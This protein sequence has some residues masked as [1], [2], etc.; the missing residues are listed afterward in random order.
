MNNI[1]LTIFTPAFN[2]ANTLERAY[3]SLKNQT[4]KNFEWL[5]IDDGSTDDTENVI[6]NLIDKKEVTIRYFK[7]QNS[8]KQAAWNKAIELSEGKYFC[9]LDSD[10]A[11][12]SENSIEEI[13]RKDIKI[14]NDFKIIG[15]RYL[16]YSNVKKTFDGTKISD[17]III[18]SW[19]EDFSNPSN[20]GERIDIFKKE[21][22]KKYLFPIE[23]GLKFIPE[24]WFYVKVSA[25]GYDFAYMPNALRL[26]YDDAVDNRLSRSSIQKHAKGHYLTRSAMLKLIPL[27]FFLRNKIAFIKTLIRFIQCSNYK[28]IPYHQR[29]KDSNSFYAILSM[30]LF[31]L[32]LR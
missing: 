27:K 9:C 23:D 11:I 19:F 22:L 13:F 24:F 8:G 5:I 7:Q 12:Y 16:A 30:I 29:K 26:F 32:T 21:P 10:D 20:F 28:K 25:D 3:A 1:E 14:L 6:K 15:L 18:M 4:L 2:R 31:F 17:D